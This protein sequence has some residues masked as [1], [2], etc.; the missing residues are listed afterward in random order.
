MKTKGIFITLILILVGTLILFVY[1]NFVQALLPDNWVGIVAGIGAALVII[2]GFL[3]N[4]DGAFNFVNKLLGKKDPQ[5]TQRKIKQEDNTSASYQ[6]FNAPVTI[7]HHPQSIP[8][9]TQSEPPIEFEDSLQPYL[10]M[11]ERRSQRLPLAPLDPTGQEIGQLGLGEL[12]INLNA[13]ESAIT[14]GRLLRKASHHYRAAI[15]HIF[16]NQRLILLGDPG[17]GKSTMLRFLALCLARDHLGREGEWLQHLRWELYQP[18]DNKRLQNKEENSEIVYWQGAAPIP[19]LLVLRDFAAQNFK[20]ADPLAIWNFACKQLQDDKLSEAQSALEYAARRGKIIFLLDGVDEVPPFDREAV[21]QAI[22]A[23]DAGVFGGNR[24]VATCRILSFDETQIPETDLPVRTLEELNRKQIDT[25][26][27]GWFDAYITAGEM[28]K[29]DG[30][31]KT[32]RLH[33]ATRRPDIFNLATN[34]ML[35]TIMAVVQ[36][37]HAT[38]PDERAKLYQACLETMLFRWQRHKERESD[39]DLP[40][41]LMQL[42]TTKERLERLLWEIAWEAHCLAPEREEAADIAEDDVLRI[43][44]DHLGDPYK[45][46]QFVEYTEKRAHLLIG[47]GGGKR[48]VYRFPHRTFQEYLAACYIADLPRA[49]KYFGDG[50]FGPQLRALAQKGDAWREVLNLV[51]GYLVYVI[52][53]P[54]DA[55]EGIAEILPEQL[56]NADDVGNWHRIWLAAEM[57]SVVKAEE[58]KKNIFGAKLL[59]QVRQQVTSLVETGRLT[60]RQRA[61]AG[62]ALG[63]LGDERKGVCEKEPWLLPITEDLQFKMGEKGEPVKIPAPYAIAKYPVTNAQFRFFVEAGGYTQKWKECWIKDG[64]QGWQYK[65]NRMQPYLWDAPRYNLDN[66]PVV[67]ISWYEAVAYANWLTAT[68]DKLY[69]LPTEAEWERAAR[70][71]DGRRYPWGNEWQEG[72]ANSDEAGIGRPTAVGIFPDGTADCGALDMSGNVWE[73]CQTRWRDENRRDYPA[74][75]RDDG[76]ENL[77]GGESVGRVLKGG[78]YYN[79]K[80]RIPAAARCGGYPSFRDFNGGVRLVVSPFIS[81][82]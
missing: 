72:F 53:R 28:T 68:T 35:L 58:A 41:V 56:P 34:P 73:W 6:E 37:Y 18:E 5:P 40:N 7:H 14:K 44:R 57:L 11:V 22:A 79:G 70:H 59:P 80:D 65:G 20:P 69:R 66:Q 33:N 3:S 36:T 39:R 51:A 10:E 4:L 23:H 2:V 67:G 77:A 9:P 30:H 29:T 25:F 49:N 12:F 19:V 26:I 61:E 47:Y 13:G 43:A 48:N 75:W 46:A 15:G 63:R 55:L 50:E 78:A 45:A 42:G 38:L 32:T 31:D 64:L 17:S 27:E 60:S 74:T 24:W 82:R 76:R 81:D 71:T 21:W 52:N 54:Q 62:D 16:H 8:E 1:D